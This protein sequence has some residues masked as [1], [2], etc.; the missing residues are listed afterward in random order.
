MMIITMMMIMTS[1]IM[2]MMM[3]M[4]MMIMMMSMIMIIMTYS[5]TYG[6]GV[7]WPPSLAKICNAPSSATWF[8]NW[9][10]KINKINK[11]DTNRKRNCIH[12]SSSGYKIGLSW[13]FHLDEKSFIYIMYGLTKKYIKKKNYTKMSYQSI[14]GCSITLNTS[15][16]SCLIVW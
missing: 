3:S 13:F 6:I 5:S 4:I 7:W 8:C 2:M 14:G 10:Q 16:I 9:I 15:Q 1:M 12:A 11:R